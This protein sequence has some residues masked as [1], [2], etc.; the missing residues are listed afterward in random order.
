MMLFPLISVLGALLF[1]PDPLPHGFGLSAKYPGDKG[2]AN[3][4][5]FLFAEDFEA[6][7]IEEVI[8]HWSEA[9][10]KDGKVLAFSADTPAASSGKRSIQIT[11]TL[12]ENTGGHLYK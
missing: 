5:N 10:N 3:D 6:G 8:R 12:G 9:S 4:A 11:A 2:I 7:A 1:G